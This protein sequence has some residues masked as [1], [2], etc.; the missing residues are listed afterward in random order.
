VDKDQLVDLETEGKTLDM[1][2]GEIESSKPFG[3]ATWR[4]SGAIKEIRWRK[5]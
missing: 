5:L 4:T 3:I 1:R 2:I